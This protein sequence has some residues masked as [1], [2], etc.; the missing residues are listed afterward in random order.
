MADDMFFAKDDQSL[1]RGKRVAKR[2][3][4]C[5]PCLVTLRE[6]DSVEYQGVVMDMTPYGMLIRIMGD[7]PMGAKVNIQLMRDETF[8]TPFSAA[9]E[10]TVMRH[11]VVPGGFTD[12]G[13]KLIIRAIPNIH[14]RP[15]SMEDVRTANRN[16]MPRPRS[17]DF[18]IGG[19][20]PRRTGR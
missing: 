1:R 19:D 6:E 3:D 14:S 9:H 5:R 16:A 8:T 10:G 17:I 7:V 2:T 13:I 11:S 20:P 12:L 4:T 15:V 18:R